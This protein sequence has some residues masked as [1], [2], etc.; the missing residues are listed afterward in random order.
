MKPRQLALS[1]R[2]F[3]QVAGGTLAASTILG[4]C[5]AEDSV[6]QVEGGGE[7]P[8][9]I[10]TQ[11]YAVRREMEQDLEG[12]IARM[13]E[14]SFEGVE[15]A[16]Y[17]GRSAAELRQVLDGNGLKPC[18]THIYL[19]TMQ[20]DQLQETVDFNLELGNPYLIVRWAQSEALARKDGWL[21]LCE[22]FN[23]AAA[24]LRPHG[25]RMGYHSHGYS[26]DMVEGECAWHILADNTEPDVI[27]QLDTGAVPFREDL[28]VVGLLKRNPG[29][30]TTIHIKPKHREIS[31]A[32]IGR[33][34]LPWEEICSVC[35]TT[36]GT[37]WYIVEYERP[38]IPPDLALKGNLEAFLEYAR[39]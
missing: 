9:L 3:L 21:Q 14:I 17:F 28:D 11:L 6:S 26:F 19:E 35:E 23:E 18:G 25:L 4:G 39:S 29:R 38:G 30:T 34:E 32:W 15:F 27:L 1:R 37:E 24:A 7:T 22:D 2:E 16:D 10:G 5:Q 20:G 8:I 13:A 31:W 36:A 12:T 33:D